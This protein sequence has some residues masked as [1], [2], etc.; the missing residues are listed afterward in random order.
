MRGRVDAEVRKVVRGC[1]VARDDLASLRKRLLERIRRVVTVEAAFFAAA[2]PE[3]LLFTSVSAEAPLIAAAPLFL[4]N[5]FGATFDVNRFAFLAGARRP[6]GTLDE[7]TGGDRA[8]SPRFREIMA[9]LQLGDELRVALRTGDTT[10]GFLC[11][12]REGKAGFSARDI[13]V[14]TGIAP[15]AGEALRRIVAGSIAQAS[16]PDCDPAVVLT[17]GSVVIG[18][19]GAAASWLDELHGSSIDIGDSVPFALLAVIRRLEALERAP[20]SAAPPRLT[21]STRRGSLLEV[22]AARVRGAEGEGAVA[23]TLAPAGAATRSSLLLA[24][25]GLTPAQRRVA[26]LVLQGLST[27]EIVEDLGIS[28]HTV[29]DHLKAVFDK[30]GVGSRRELVA[31][32]RR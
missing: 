14:L 12:H 31:A 32:L 8:S 9:P 13:A 24:A 30:V 18:M 4:A 2:D 7:A 5:E 29:Q 6:I 15:H 11:L 17:Q 27:R 1:Y 25:R 26:A 10:W 28:E 3:T 21:I 23:I 20:D 16:R 19:T 22:H